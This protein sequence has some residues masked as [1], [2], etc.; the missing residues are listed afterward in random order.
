MLAPGYYAVYR[1]TVLISDGA[2]TRVHKRDWLVTDGT[3]VGLFDKGESLDWVPLK[4]AN[5]QS[6]LLD[7]ALSAQ[8]HSVTVSTSF[9]RLENTFTHLLDLGDGSPVPDMPRPSIREGLG[10]YLRA[11]RRLAASEFSY[12][13]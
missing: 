3:H 8:L 4:W 1:D 11:R 13:R 6:V 9:S 2:R 7:E 5:G 12:R 10:T